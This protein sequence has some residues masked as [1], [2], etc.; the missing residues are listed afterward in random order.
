MGK[1]RRFSVLEHDVYKLKT[2][3]DEI[4]QQAQPECECGNVLACN[5]CDDEKYVEL[6]NWLAELAHHMQE[7]NPA[8]ASFVPC[9]CETC[10]PINE[11]Y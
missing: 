5:E 9:Y 4:A 11:N 7:N 1:R 8:G 6:F 2:D 10:K 3:V